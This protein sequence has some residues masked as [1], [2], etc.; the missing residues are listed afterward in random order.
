MKSYDEYMNHIHGKAEK[1]RSRRRRM[2][3]SGIASVLAL[4]VIVSVL[5]SGVFAR[6]DTEQSPNLY[7][8]TTGESTPTEG[9]TVPDTPTT[10]IEDDPTMPIE[11]DPTTPPQEPGNSIVMADAY[12][13]HTTERENYS[14]LLEHLVDSMRDGDR[15]DVEVPPVS[16]EPGEFGGSESYVEVTDNQT[17]GVI[18]GDLFKRSDKYLYYLHANKLR[19]YS[20]AGESSALVGEA[21]LKELLSQGQEYRYVSAYE[22][23]LSADCRSVTIVMRNWGDQTISLLSLDVSEPSEIRRIA[24]KDFCGLSCSTRLVGNTLLLSYH[25]EVYA[26][27]EPMNYIPSYGEAG[28]MQPMDACDIYCPSDVVADSYAV[29]AKLDLTTLEVA[30]MTALVGYTNM[31]Y[32]SD[33]TIYATRTG[34][35]RTENDDGYTDIAQTAVTGIGYDESGLQL[36]GTVVLDGYVLDPYWMDEYEGVLRVAATTQVTTKSHVAL[37]DGWYTLQ[38]AAECNCSLYCV[39]L[40][41]WTICASVVNFAPSGDEVTSA[42]FDGVN[43]YICTAEVAK[44]TD[45]VYF[46]DLSDLQNI[47]YK[48]TPII[49]GYSSSLIRFGDHLIGIGIDSGQTLKIEVYVE[50]EDGVESV[51]AFLRN[52]YSSDDYKSYYIDRENGILGIPVVDYEEYTPRYLL[53]QLDGDRWQLLHEIDLQW[54][55][56]SDIRATV[57]DGY[58][59]IL[60]DTLHIVPMN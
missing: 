45:P 11:D 8:P 4:A 25:Y 24:R 10:P 12:L 43:A 60:E 37:G 29:F 35:D 59:Y 48:H 6:P 51:D 23:Y 22:M 15:A 54:S 52:A 53:L 32:V 2:A 42:R 36:K 46:F 5:L 28:D 34:L 21:D 17:A 57:I 55:S 19:V 49:D 3:I 39:D 7:H 41:D 27:D 13:K 47:Q 38:Y 44:Y 1:M 58:L 30:D 20:I 14:W 40:S 31:I 33:S 9:Q 56:L 16:D 26:L 50:T 18:E